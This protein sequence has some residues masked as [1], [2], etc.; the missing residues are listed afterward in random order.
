ME[1]TDMD[2]R[3]PI[4]LLVFLA[5][6][7]LFTITA[8]GV[9]AQSWSQMPGKV[10]EIA[11][12]GDSTVSVWALGEGGKAYQWSEE[13][14]T[15]QDYGGE[16][17]LIAVTSDGTPWVVENEQLYRLRGR[18]WQNMPG[19]AKAIAAGKTVWSVGENGAVYSW[20]SEAFEWMSH[21][22]QAEEIAVTADGRPWVIEDEQI[23][24]L[25]GQTW[26]NM[27]G[28]AKSIAA[29]GGT[30]WCVGED[31]AVYKWDEESFTWQNFGGKADRIGVTSAGV[32]WVVEDGPGGLQVYR[33]R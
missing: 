16:A 19:K 11:A 32:P 14:A 15:W 22:G 12:S 25:R 30:V 8:R 4:F 20:N 6:T 33:L 29:G 10:T 17:E 13:S 3:F 27:P 1:N 24:R 9:E 21:G 28:K 31:E 5:A 18:N 7:V 23:Y 2:K 26:Q